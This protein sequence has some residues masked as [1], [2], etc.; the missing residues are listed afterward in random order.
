MPVLAPYLEQKALWPTSGRHILAQYTDDTVIVYQAYSP[1][2]AEWAV[3]HQQLGGPWSFE[4]TSWIKP[5]FL[6]MMYRSGWADKPYQERILAITI[7]RA[8]FDTILSQVVESSYHPEVDGPDRDAWRARGK[9]APVRMQW[10]PDHAPGGSKEGRRA[11]QLGLRQDTLRRFALEWTRQIEDVT[12][13]VN[14]QRAY[15]T[16]D[17]HASLLT[18]AERVYVPADPAIR[19]R[20]RLTQAPG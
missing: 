10:D 4:R 20:I 14:Q 1:A 12:P 7:D 19:Q 8:G 2:I 11:I 16:A 6:W 5:N 13:L 18:P 9:A 3:E 15:R 17:R